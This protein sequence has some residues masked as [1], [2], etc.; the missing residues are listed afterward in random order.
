ME[1]ISKFDK[2]LARLIKK[3]MERPQINKIGN[4]K[5]VTTDFI[6]I[7]SIIKDFY[8]QCYSNK[9]GKLEEMDMFLERYSFPSLKQEEIENMNRPITNTEIETVTK[10]LPTNKSLGPDSF[11]GEF[12]Q[13]LREDLTYILLKLLRN[14]NE[15]KLSQSFYESIIMLISKPRQRYHKKGKLLTNITD[16]HV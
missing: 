3:I 10:N 13:T 2:T 11:T 4:E 12:Y 14:E 8:E 5:E 9:M 7:P 1:K 15:R 16:D 6:E